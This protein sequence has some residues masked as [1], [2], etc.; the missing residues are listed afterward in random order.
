MVLG[1]SHLSYIADGDKK[2]QIFRE[3]HLQKY[4]GNQL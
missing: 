2:K 1:E 4:S 3:D